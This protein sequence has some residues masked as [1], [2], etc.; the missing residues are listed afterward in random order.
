[1]STPLP[2]FSNSPSFALLYLNCPASLYT[3]E[4]VQLMVFGNK[5]TRTIDYE[6]VLPLLF[7]H[8][9]YSRYCKDAAIF[10]NT[11][12]YESLPLWTGNEELG[13]FL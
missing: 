11:G 12:E 9:L 3:K 7:L 2:C 8:E 10:T 13:S 5:R 4:L 6:K 1:M